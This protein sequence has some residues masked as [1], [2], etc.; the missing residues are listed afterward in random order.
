[1]RGPPSACGCQ[2]HLPGPFWDL[3]PSAV[4]GWGGQ[5]WWGWRLAPGTPVP[6]VQHRHHTWDTCPVGAMP[7]F[8]PCSH[9]GSSRDRDSQPV[10]MG[11]RLAWAG[12][13]CRASEYLLLPD[14]LTQRRGMLTQRP[15]VWDQQRGTTWREAGWRPGWDLPLPA[16]CSAGQP[17]LPRNHD[18]CQ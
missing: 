14:V 2:T 3:C 10:S 8:L 11:L 17:S 9:K 13:R 5:G 4:G 18:L 12:H 6:G 1:M 15:Q 16:P 7:A